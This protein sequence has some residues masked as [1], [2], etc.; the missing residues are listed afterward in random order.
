[1]LSKAAKNELVQEFNNVFKS[2]PSVLV[3]E[4][5]GLTVNELQGLRANLNKAEAELK[6][7]KN[8]LLKIA[9]KDTDIEQITELFEGP[10]AVAICKKDPTEVAK[11]FVDSAKKIPLLKIKGGVVDGS[12]LNETEISALSK[13]PSREEMIAQ[14][15][16]LIS[17]PMSNFLGTLVQLQTQFLYALNALKEKKEKEEN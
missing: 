2:G 4:Y 14:F 8:T 11:V 7:V 3:V 1:M 6:V 12:V 13:L 17:S 5:K 15:M 9:A 16:G 10:T